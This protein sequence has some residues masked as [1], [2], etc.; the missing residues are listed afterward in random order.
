MLMLMNVQNYAHRHPMIL[1]LFS[2]KW[3]PII[4]YS[5]NYAGTLG[6]SLLKAYL[7]SYMWWIYNEDRHCTYVLLSYPF[8]CPCS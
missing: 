1:E 4:H 7:C 5:P 8:M 6:S 3:I 2:L